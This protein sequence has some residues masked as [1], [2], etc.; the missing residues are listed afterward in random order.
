MSDKLL[1]DEGAREPFR[2]KFVIDDVARITFDNKLYDYKL[3]IYNYPKK[4]LNVEDHEKKGF[5]IVYSTEHVEDDRSFS[6]DSADRGT[7]KLRAQPVLKTT[8]DGYQE[9][10]MRRLKTR[11]RQEDIKSLKAQKEK[12][13]RST[14]KHGNELHLDDGEITN[15][16]L[17]NNT[18]FED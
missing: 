11:A 14:K 10:L 6:P 15:D 7:E 17:N 8:S 1:K 4:P 16:E 3:V 9:V 2:N 13:L 12:Y 18:K 5:E